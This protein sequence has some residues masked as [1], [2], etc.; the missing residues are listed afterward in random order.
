MGKE[1]VV[2][3]LD[4]MCDLMCDNIIPKDEMT[5]KEFME[6]FSIKR[7]DFDKVQPTQLSE[8][9]GT[10]DLICPYCH[11]SIQYEAEDIDDILGGTPYQCPE[12]GKWFYAEGEMSISTTSTPIEDIVLNRK[13]YI[14]SA[15]NHMDECDKK[16]VR[17]SYR[18]YGNCEWTTYKN[19]AEPLFENQE[20]EEEE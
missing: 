9:Y 8:E 20:M 1:I 13:S 3:N 18:P 2:N 15:Y 7:I 6:Y 14:Q 19:Y 11:E 16:G 12:C 10:D 17:F 5:L 4:E